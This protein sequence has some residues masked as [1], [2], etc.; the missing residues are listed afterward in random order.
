DMNEA[1]WYSY[2]GKA[3]KAADIDS[4]IYKASYAEINSVNNNELGKLRANLRENTFA[5]WLVDHNDKQA[6]SY[7]LYAKKCEPYAA[8]QDGHWDNTTN[9]WKLTPRDTAAMTALITEGLQ[10]HKLAGNDFFKWRYKYQVLR[11]AMYSGHYQQTLSLYNE[12][13]GDNKYNGIMYARCLGMKAGALYK[14]NRKTEAAYLYSLIFDISDEMKQTALISFNWAL[15]SNAQL[16]WPLCK[17]DHEKA[18]V[19]IM[20]ALYETSGQEKE[21]LAL[22]E[23]AYKLDP[24]V[25]GLN[26]VM[27]RE[28]NKAEQRY[29]QASFN[30]IPNAYYYQY[31]GADDKRSI[32]SIAHSYSNYIAGLNSFALK[33]ANDS[34]LNDKAF[35]HLS[36]AYIYFMQG[37]YADCKKHLDISQKEKMTPIERDVHDVVYA[38]YIVHSN[39]KVTEKTEADLLPYLKWIETRSDSNRRFAK[40][41]TDML[42]SVLCTAYLQQGDTVKAIFCLSRTKFDKTSNYMLDY[43]FMDNAGTLL[44]KMTIDELHKVQ[45]FMQSTAKTP[46]DNWL[47]THTPYSFSVLRE[48][49]GTK[50]IR[51]MQFDKAVTV[52]KDV[53]QTNL[54]NII[55]PDVLISHIQDMQD[56]LSS[57][58]A[59]SYNKL[60]FA[61]KMAELQQKLNANPKDGRAAYQFANGLYNMSYYG[62]AHHAF[63]YYRSSTDDHAYIATKERSKLPEYEQE[64]Y[65]V[66]LAEKY[67]MQA[68][69]NST[70]PE[71]KARCLFMAAK[72]WQKSCPQPEGKESSYYNSYY[73][74]D[75]YLNSLKNPYFRQL[76]KEYDKTKFFNDA[77]NTCSYLKD[78]VKAQ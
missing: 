29:L 24:N 56:W 32:D 76:K 64:Y 18:V 70:A 67:Y 66:K 61:M 22:M 55:L 17:T 42:T 49:E 57:D 8:E 3:V 45:A 37:N 38:L 68:Y 74:K 65:N 28:I 71:V 33:L 44:E 25:K 50:Y 36:A 11:M 77:Y 30:T 63:D 35:W 39:D 51:E 16:V 21:G 31:Y 47:T 12:L 14:T 5:K 73:D 9:E 53:S 2:T 6:L 58:S 78:Y 69:T 4:F 20:D 43:G 10:Q 75:Y 41:Y 19:D 62:K 48:L 54:N 34:K 15:N 60:S 52:L 7:L 40:V 13:I 1:E 59:V 46:Y 23:E 27:T 72:C 26:V